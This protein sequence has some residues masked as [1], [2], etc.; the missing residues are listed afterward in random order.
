LGISFPRFLFFF[1]L[2]DLSIWIEV[3]VEAVEAVGGVVAVEAVVVVLM[4]A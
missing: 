3:G 1:F 4:E 2:S